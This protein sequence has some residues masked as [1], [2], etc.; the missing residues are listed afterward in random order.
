MAL[1]RDSSKSEWCKEWCVADAVSA[2]L[3]AFIHIVHHWHTFVHIEDA[4]CKGLTL[5]EGL[6]CAQVWEH[7]L[8]T[9]G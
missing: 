4:Y 8:R 5:L 3:L 6:Y 2:H 1:I 9:V 7:T